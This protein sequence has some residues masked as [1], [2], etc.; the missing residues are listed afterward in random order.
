[1]KIY[2]LVLLKININGTKMQVGFLEV[3]KNTV[4]EDYRKNLMNVIRF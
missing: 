4:V 2:W 3:I 1:M